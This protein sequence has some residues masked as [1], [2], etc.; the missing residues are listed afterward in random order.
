MNKGH[1]AVCDYEG[2]TYRTDFWE[3][4]GREYED[5][6]E[7]VA[8][9]TLLPKAGQRYVEFGAGFGRLANEAGAFDQIVLV[10]YSRTLLQEAQSR[11]GTSGRYIYIAADLYHLPFA[12]NAFDVAIMCRVIHHLTDAPTA[13]RQIRASLAP[14][15]T[16]VLEFAN[17]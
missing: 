2:S 11:L 7:R 15:A 5:A 6:V 17:K 14:G 3:G 1:P 10:D 16:F 8:L 9:R 4:K 12:P 13:L